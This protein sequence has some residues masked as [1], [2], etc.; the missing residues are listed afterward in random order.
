[1]SGDHDPM[2]KKVALLAFV[3]I[4]TSAFVRFEPAPTDL[5]LLLLVGVGYFHGAF[6]VSGAGAFTWIGAVSFLILSTASLMT[7]WRAVTSTAYQA[8]TVFMFVMFFTIAGLVARYGRPALNVLLRGYCLS[9]LIA[10]L[11]GILAR[12]HLIPHSEMFFRSEW[13]LRINSTFKD[14]NVFAPFLVGALLVVMNDYFTGKRRLL[15]AI[16]M[17]GAYLLGILFA[18]SRGAFLHLAISLV[19][20]VVLCLF[21]VRDVRI[22][23]KMLVGLSVGT[24][25]AIAGLALAL[26]TSGLDGF[27]RSRMGYQSYDNERFGMQKLALEVASQNLLGIGPGEWRSPRFSNDPH[28]VYLRVLAENGI[29]A[30]LAWLAFLGACLA[31]SFV[32]LL[33]RDA[34]APVHAACLAVLIGLLLESLF[35]DTL[36]WRHLFFFLAVPVGLAGVGAPA[37]QSKR[38]VAVST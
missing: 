11:I 2:P 31:R 20:Y 33:R 32:A 4:A 21:V 9:A 28:N 17:S 13:G 16:A 1:M 15:P 18:F 10:A 29:L 3:T 12:F 6:R 24:G 37:S 19:V 26:S 14:A 34:H 25:L 30:A 22:S 27:L 7:A 36:H 38:V 8:V 23:R 35:I 5:F